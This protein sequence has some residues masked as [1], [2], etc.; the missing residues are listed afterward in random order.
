MN[1]AY[2]GF[3]ELVTAQVAAAIARTD[4]YQRERERARALAEID[5]AKTAF[6]SNISHEFRTPLT[7]MLGPLEDTL[8]SGSLDPGF[9]ERLNL[10]HRNALRLLRLV[11][12][13]LDFSRT[14]AGRVQVSYRPTDLAA[15]TADLASSFRSA[16]DRAGLRLIVQ[17]PPLSEPVYVD[18][19]MWE[20]IVLNLLSNAFKFTFEGEIEVALV[21]E[22]DRVRLIVRDTGAG[23]PESELSRLFDRFHRIEGAK[24]RSFEGSGI[25]LALVQ[26]MVRQHGG[27]VEV[28]SREGHGSTFSVIVPLGAEHLPPERIAG[29]VVNAGSTAARTRSFVEEA[30]RWLPG[31]HARESLLDDEDLT[32]ITPAAPT[33]GERRPRIL[34]V[35][36]SADLRAYISRLL[37]A[38]GFEVETASD[39]YAALQAL[40]DNSADLVVTDVMM[41][42]LDGFGLLREI[43]GDAMLREL[44]VIMLSARAGEEAQIEGLDA[45]VDDYLTKPFSA[46]ELIARVSANI[47]LARIRREATEV[48]RTS[49]QQ[50]RELERH[51]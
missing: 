45:G 4:E 19:D 39:G 17:T 27:C 28:E 50:L 22:Q 33:D 14:E 9:R 44:P 7:L 47:K 29:R 21:E 41:P 11:N 12:S 8:E 10:V 2:Q 18:K 1:Q 20:K 3:I 13:L 38:R 32:E 25:G 31:D 16:T 51:T 26:E 43:R 49:E 35:D 42:R 30:L 15:L 24:G 36:D 23:I 34:L 46:R 37:S 6:F 48:I 5:T 40:R